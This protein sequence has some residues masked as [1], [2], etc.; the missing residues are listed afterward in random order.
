M[1]IANYRQ[2]VFK[3]NKE[4]KEDKILWRITDFTK[5]ALIG[6]EELMDAIYVTNVLKKNIRLFRL[7]IRYFTDEYEY[8]WAESF[9]LELVDDNG[10]SLYKFPD[11]SAISDLYDTVKYKTSNIADLFNDF[12]KDSI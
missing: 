3:L 7:K 10:N 4:T 2:F 12:L 6:T 5:P 1:E 8:E 9:R 11:D